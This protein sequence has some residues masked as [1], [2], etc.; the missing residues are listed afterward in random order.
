MKSSC[1]VKS[2]PIPALLAGVSPVKASVGVVVSIFIFLP[3]EVVSPARSV[4]YPV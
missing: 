1:P 4:A 3:V 2:N